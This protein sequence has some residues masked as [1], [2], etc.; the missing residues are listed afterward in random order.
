METL[1]YIKNKYSLDLEQ[2]S[3]I[4]LPMNRFSGLCGLFAELQFK[5]GAEIGVDRGRYSKWLLLKNRKLKLFCIDPYLVYSE[6]IET[7]HKGVKAMNASHEHAK[8]RLGKLNCEIIVKTSMEALGDFEDN[9]LDFVFIDGNHSFEY[10]VDDIAGW[11]KKVRPGG[12]ISGH[13]YWNSWEDEE[14]MYLKKYTPFQKMKL[15]QVKDAVDAWT[16]TNQIKTW[17]ILNDQTWF[18]IKQ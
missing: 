12:I 11:S 2:P 15:V 16:K 17:F 3:P 8:Q 10:V 13:D 4:M 6:Y 7:H 14:R 1:K 9:S 18:Y 5:V